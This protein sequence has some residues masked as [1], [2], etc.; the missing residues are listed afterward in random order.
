[1]PP[2]TSG[3]ALNVTFRVHAVRRHRQQTAAALVSAAPPGNRVR[4]LPLPGQ[5]G[6]TPVPMLLTVLVTPRIPQYGLNGPHYLP[7]HF[8]TA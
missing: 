1:M 5:P 8:I 6:G 7:N 3:F 2:L 4:T